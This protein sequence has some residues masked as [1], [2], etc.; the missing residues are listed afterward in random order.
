VGDVLKAITKLP[1]VDRKI[2]EFAEA[3]KRDWAKLKPGEKAAAIGAAVTLGAGAV[4][5]IASDP[6]ARKMALGL[7]DGQSFP[8]PGVPGLTMKVQTQN[9]GGATLTFDLAEI[10]KPLK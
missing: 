7:L 9:G 10:I 8:V 3:R 1:E 5:G 2:T 4:S 6:A